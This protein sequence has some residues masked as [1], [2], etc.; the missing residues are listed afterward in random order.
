[1]LKG[2]DNKYYRL[3]EA[4]KAIAK[5]SQL[6]VRN[7][8][9]DADWGAVEITRSLPSAISCLKKFVVGNLQLPSYA[10]ELFGMQVPAMTMGERISELE[11]RFNSDHPSSL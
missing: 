3:V 2:P 10:W 7:Q 5:P 4:L 8:E 11:R 1:V 9:Y 6:V